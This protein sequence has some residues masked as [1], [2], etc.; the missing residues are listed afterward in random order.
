[1]KTV[2]VLLTAALTVVLA[3][4][5]TP[6]APVFIP[7][8]DAPNAVRFLPAPPS[9]GTA[10]FLSDKAGY[11]RGK[12][13]R[14]GARGEQARL[15]ANPRFDYTLSLFAGPFGIAVS[16]SLTP[17]TY[18][19]IS[20]VFQAARKYA[21]RDAKP[22]YRR[23]RPFV[24]FGEASLTPQYDAEMADNWSY[25]SGHTA[26]A[27]CMA[28]TL[29]S[30]NPA[31]QDTLF[32][33]AYEYGQ[34]R[35]ICGHH[36]PSDVEAGRM[37]AAAL[38]ARLQTDSAYLSCWAKAKEEIRKLDSEGRIAH[39]QPTAGSLYVPNYGYGD[40]HMIHANLTGTKR[41]TRKAPYVP[42]ADFANSLEILPAP[43]QEHS[44]E[45]LY[46]Q[47]QYFDGKQQRLTPRADVA[48][49]DAEFSAK[50]FAANF[51]GAFGIL[52]S[53]EETPQL[54][55]LLRAVMKS[56]SGTASQAKNYYKRT[57][58]YAYYNQGSLV[59]KDEEEL[60]TNGSFPS[61]HTTMGTV[62]GLILAEINIANEDT[63]LKRTYDYG[64]SR[65]IAGYHWQ[66]DV[67]AGR[68]LGAT[69]VARL[70]ADKEFIKQLRK[71]KKEFLRLD[72]AGKIRH[73]ETQ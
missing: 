25:P 23:P 65:V 27:Y 17:E 46:D 73:Y 60:R 9:E 51:A 15:N 36:W 49:A 53:E 31:N 48:I 34:S 68:Y 29:A 67:N 55:K 58:P 5:Q 42:A 71:A 13:L 61:G 26:R 11:F 43:P 70:H 56:E 66:S 45:F 4:A 39:P 72:K 69:F 24:F 50:G 59:P 41:S 57:R 20:G 28:F 44:V 1:M 6:Q 62:W 38:F 12:T 52:I 18:R 3:S 22:H 37:V 7:D 21:T 32:Q 30:L 33:F 35:I 19:L 2:S 10:L 14:D 54:W 40:H 64:Q 8:D 63:I 16:D 47:Y